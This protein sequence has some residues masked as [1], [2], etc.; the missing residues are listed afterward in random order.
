MTGKRAFV[1]IVL[2]KGNIGKLN[3]DGGALVSFEMKRE[4]SNHTEFERYSV[5]SLNFSKSLI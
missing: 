3:Y 5:S 2:K 4:V 1:K